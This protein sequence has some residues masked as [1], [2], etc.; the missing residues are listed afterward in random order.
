MRI[1]LDNNATTKPDPAVIAA[2][3]GRAGSFNGNDPPLCAAAST[4]TKERQ[5]AIV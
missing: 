5:A 1:Y 2:V 4:G 3:V